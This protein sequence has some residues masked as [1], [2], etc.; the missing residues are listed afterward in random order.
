MAAAAAAWKCAAAL[1]HCAKALHRQTMPA[2][3]PHTP[4]PHHTGQALC[5]PCPTHWRLMPVHA[6][7]LPEASPAAQQPPC[8]AQAAAS[9][10]H[11]SRCSAAAVRGA[12]ARAIDASAPRT[13][14]L[15]SSV[16]H[17]RCSAS[18]AASPTLLRFTCRDSGSALQAPAM[19]AAVPASQSWPCRV[20]MTPD[21][22][23]LSAISAALCSSVHSLGD[24]AAAYGLRILATAST[25]MGSSGAPNLDK[26]GVSSGRS[27]LAKTQVACRFGQHFAYT[28]SNLIRL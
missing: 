19:L 12:P 2:P 5:W 24:E 13:W 8:G 14:S 1:A 16:P 4:P 17:V 18:H 23:W 25:C 28:C 7:R 10:E 22:A 9:A 26:P 3:V 20:A 21:S 27:A 15:C 6:L 11:T